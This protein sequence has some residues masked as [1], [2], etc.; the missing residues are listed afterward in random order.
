MALGSFK[1]DQIPTTTGIPQGSPLSP[2]LFLFFVSTLLPLLQ[3]PT[4]TAVGFVDDTNILTWSDCTEENCRMLEG[5]HQIC[6]RWAREH[7]VRFAPEKYQLMHF[8]RARKRHNLKATVNIQGHL[9]TPQS[10][11]RVLGVYFDPKLNWGA[12]IKKTQQRAETQ[13][14]TI[15]KLTQSTWGATFH[16]AKM[17]YNTIVRPALTYGSP[18]WAMTG[19]GNKIPE[20]IIKPLRTIQRQCLLNITGAYKSTSTRVLEHET[21]IL[22]MEIYLK[23]RRVQY[24]GLTHNLPVQKTIEKSCRKIRQHNGANYIGESKSKERDRKEWSTICG[25]EESIKRQKEMGK[26]AAYQEWAIKWPHGNNNAILRQRAIANP[27]VWKAATFYI[28]KRNG[29]RKVSLKG[30]PYSF[31]KHLTKAQSSIAIQI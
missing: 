27:E 8:T 14:Q 20:R 28:D 6:E 23:H 19:A 16:K 9:T 30:T 3:T 15:Q 4:S 13:V 17:L 10:S 7:G 18:I 29:G 12:H 22:P 24:A 1:G 5:K 25:G 2:I 21:S 31:H 11:L 26:A